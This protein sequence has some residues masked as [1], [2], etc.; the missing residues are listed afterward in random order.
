M[1]KIT[2]ISFLLILYT[3]LVLLKLVPL[4]YKPPYVCYTACYWLKGCFPL[5]QINLF[6]RL[7]L[8]K[9]KPPKSSADWFATHIP[10]G[11]RAVFSYTANL[12]SVPVTPIGSQAFYKLISLLQIWLFFFKGQIIT[13]GCIITPLSYYTQEHSYNTHID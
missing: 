5:Q 4:A 1:K 2:I 3:V 9:K 12:S 13:W 11:P 6:H 10:I 7:L 8:G